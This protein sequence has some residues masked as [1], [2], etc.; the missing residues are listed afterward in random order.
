MPVGQ[1][2]KPENNDSLHALVRE[3]IR[4]ATELGKLL[5]HDTDFQHL[6]VQVSAQIARSL[7]AGGKVF[8]FGNGGSAADAQHLA[9]EFTGRYLKE[10]RAFPALALHG[11]SSAGT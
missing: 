10:R 7:R 9:A 6:T 4:Q 3:R 2:M 5:L 8:F 1:P 11:N